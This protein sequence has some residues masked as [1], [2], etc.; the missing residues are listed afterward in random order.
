[1]CHTHSPVSSSA[2]AEANVTPF[3][4]RRPRARKSSARRTRRSE[5]SPANSSPVPPDWSQR[6]GAALRC[7]GL[8]TYNELIHSR[9]RQ[10]NVA[11][12][13]ADL[14]AEAV[15]WVATQPTDMGVA[16]DELLTGHWLIG[17]TEESDSEYMGGDLVSPGPN[18][19]PI[20]KSHVSFPVPGLMSSCLSACMGTECGL[21]CRL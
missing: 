11:R 16:C 21:P 4:R 13:V 19:G 1:M 3:Q 5:R 9:S 10:A 14:M 12:R 18:S 2:E 6:Q 7:A 17:S 8:H 15:A 20:I